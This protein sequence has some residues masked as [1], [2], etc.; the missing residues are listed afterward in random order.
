MA[1]VLEENFDVK[2]ADLNTGLQL[3]KPSDYWISPEKKL[4]ICA[5]VKCLN[6]SVPSIMGI[7][8]VCQELKEK[9]LE[10]KTECKSFNV[11]SGGNVKAENNEIVFKGHVERVE[12]D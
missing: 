6:N 10:S 1:F 2:I 5:V 9:I 7:K 4:N 12:I 3:C 11:C 8:K